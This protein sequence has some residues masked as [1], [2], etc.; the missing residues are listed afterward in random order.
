MLPNGRVPIVAAFCVAVCTIAVLACASPQADAPTSD[1]PTA[2]TQPA[3]AQ[4]GAA[5]SECANCFQ[6]G[7][8]AKADGDPA[9]AV[10]LFEVGCVQ[11]DA[12]SFDFKAWSSTFSAF[13]PRMH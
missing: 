3:A 1:A 5:Q 2:P 12:Q 11:N 9:R 13:H 6:D 8:K 4:P 10:R 7:V